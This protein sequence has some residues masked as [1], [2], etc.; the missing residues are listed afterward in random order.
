MK[1]TVKASSPDT[2][3]EQRP[4]EGDPRQIR[5]LWAALSHLEREATSL[6]GWDVG[7]L[8]ACA[9]TA[10]EQRW[11]GVVPPEKPRGLLH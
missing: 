5:D 6:V 4:P 8:I 11:S 10:L 1:G 7:T 9:R 3:E 2:P